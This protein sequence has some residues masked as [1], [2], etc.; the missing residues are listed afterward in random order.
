LQNAI[1]TAVLETIQ[2]GLK[3]NLWK[4]LDEEILNAIRG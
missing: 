1:E 3:Q 4:I 2:I